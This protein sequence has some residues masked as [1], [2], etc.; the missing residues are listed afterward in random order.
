MML[1]GRDLRDIMFFRD[2]APVPG[3]P[4]QAMLDP[5]HVLVGPCVTESPS[6]PDAE[7]RYDFFI[8]GDFYKALEFFS[9][10]PAVFEALQEQGDRP[11]VNWR[12][13][14]NTVID[15][16]EACRLAVVR[17][18]GSSYTETGRPVGNE[19]HFGPIWATGLDFFPS[20]ELTQKQFP[21]LP[22]RL[23]PKL[24]GRKVVVNDDQPAGLVRVV[25]TEIPGRFVGEAQFKFAKREM[26]T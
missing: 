20:V 8:H 24:F 2:G 3:I 15:A 11:A 1:E 10:Y 19:I 16:C 6:S 9:G 14:R 4:K 22:G 17:A 7:E 23:F 5:R 18:T 25:E 26:R 21:L 13:I 12:E